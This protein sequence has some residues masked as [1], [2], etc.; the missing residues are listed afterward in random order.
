MSIGLL[1]LKVD[2]GSRKN[3]RKKVSLWAKKPDIQRANAAGKILKGQDTQP[4]I[5]LLIP[6]KLNRKEAKFVREVEA[7]LE[8]FYLG[9]LDINKL[10]QEL[11]ALEVPDHGKVKDDVFSIVN[12]MSLDVTLKHLNRHGLLNNRPYIFFNLS[13][14]R[15]LI[16]MR[17]T[18]NI[19]KRVKNEPSI[20]INLGKGYITVTT[21][22]KKMRKHYFIEGETLRRVNN[23][24]K[25]RGA[26]YYY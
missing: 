20:N 9:K 8:R 24:N 6:E 5:E 3:S 26:H 11:T 23:V 12:Q 14:E 22:N 7:L 1:G 15:C 21:G 18:A 25:L 16:A 10:I 17:P 13:E 2:S 4:I 19:D